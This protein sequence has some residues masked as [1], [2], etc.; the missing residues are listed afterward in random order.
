MKTMSVMNDSLIL[1]IIEDSDEDFFAIERAFK[2][3]KA[4]VSISRSKSGC[5]GMDLLTSIANTNFLSLPDI[6]LLDLNL[7]GED[8]RKILK[9]IKSDRAL[10]HIPTVIMCISRDLI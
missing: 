10:K 1:L 5:Q 9:K 4:S 7:P 8:G 3:I 6:I 2:K